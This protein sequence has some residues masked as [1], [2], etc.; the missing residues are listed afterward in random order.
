MTEY[1]HFPLQIVHFDVHLTMSNDPPI[2]LQLTVVD[3]AS[4]RDSMLKL[5][6]ALWALHGQ[7]RTLQASGNGL[8]GAVLANGPGAASDTV[9]KDSEIERY[10]DEPPTTLFFVDLTC[11]SHGSVSCRPQ[12]KKPKKIQLLGAQ[13]D[14]Q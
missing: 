3:A 2:Q 9:S 12:K 7:V 6:W 13:P 1:L 8:S 14:S 4:A 11:R 5:T 10:R